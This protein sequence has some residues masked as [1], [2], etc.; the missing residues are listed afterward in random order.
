MLSCN[1]SHFASQCTHPPCFDILFSVAEV[2]QEEVAEAPAPEEAAPTPAPED[3]SDPAPAPE[4]ESAPAPAAEDE[5]APAPAAEEAEAENDEDKPVTEE[6]APAAAEEEAAP[7]ADAPVEEAVPPVASDTLVDEIANATPEELAEM[8]KAASKVQS[9]YRGNEARKEVEALKR[10]KAE[11]ELQAVASAVAHAEEAAEAGDDA[12]LTAE[13]EA[14]LAA[15]AL[16]IQ[17]IQRG[18]NARKEVEE[19]KKKQ[20]EAG[21][22]LE[23]EEAAVLA[24]A[25]AAAQKVQG[26]EEMT[27]ED[28]AE[29]EKAA[30][31]IQA[32]Q[33]GQMARKQAAEMKKAKAQA[34]ADNLTPTTKEVDSIFGGAAPTPSSRREGVRS[35]LDGTVVPVLRQGLRMLVKTKPEDPFEFLAEYIRTHKPKGP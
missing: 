31:K 16:K 24:E 9:L 26:V 34:A 20:A 18:R 30:L 17:S 23:A 12:P 25:E 35:Y 27:L 21:G 8:D 22:T 28:D 13:E 5:S 3:A 1:P 7:A 4:D 32:M 11:A 2:P 33:R 29:L 15:A 19:L 10:A 14:E 6:A